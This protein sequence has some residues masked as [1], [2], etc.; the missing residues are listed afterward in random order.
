MVDFKI[1][2]PCAPHELPIKDAQTIVLIGANG[3]G[4]SHLGAWIELNNDNVLRISAQRAL[5]IPEV[6]TV[7]SQENSWNKINYGSETELNKNYKWDWGRKYTTQLIND[8]ESVLSAFFAIKN[9]ENDAYVQDCKLKEAKGEEK[10]NVPVMIDDKVYEIWNSVFPHRE[11]LLKDAKVKARV[12]QNSELYLARE[13][14]DGERVAI[15]LICQCLI[16]PSG[17]II[18]IDEP[19]IHLHKSIMLKLWDKIEKYCGDKLLIYITHDLDFAASRRESQKIWVKSYDGKEWSLILLEASSDIPDSLMFEV[20]GNRKPVLFVEGERGSYDNQLYPYIYEH[21]SIIPCHN[22]SN[23]INMT[24]AFNNGKV[25]NMHNYDIKGLIDRDYLTEGEVDA[26]REHNVFALKVAEVENLYLTEKV[27]KIVAEHLV[28]KE[29]EIF[30]KVKEM[31]F[32]E[33]RADLENQLKAICVKEIRHDLQGFKRPSESTPESLR[34]A[35]RG[36][37]ESVNIEEIYSKNKSRF[38]QILSTNNY[39]EL[40]KVFNNKGLLKRVSSIFELKPDAYANLVLRLIKTSKKGDIVGAL[41]QYVPNL[42]E[43]LN[44]R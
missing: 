43:E 32:S 3:S 1:K 18:V 39:D 12:A 4:K 33:F 7:K 10:G 15:Y 6:I 38:N 44:H 26:Y 22:C 24:K 34:A 2:L 17:T 27:V 23:V 42:D 29:D 19:E 21:Y 5:S 14:S 20:L 30:A 35:L 40:L 37:M 8:F 31:V 28:L 25:K 13:M 9:K 36:L 16:A 11:I 41:R